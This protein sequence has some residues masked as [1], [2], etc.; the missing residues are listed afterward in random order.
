[1]VAVAGVIPMFAF[2]QALLALSLPPA[3][4]LPGVPVVRVSDPPPVGMAEVAETTVVPIALDVIT[5]VQVALG[6]PPV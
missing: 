2:T 1:L 3:A 5:T 4:M 6:V